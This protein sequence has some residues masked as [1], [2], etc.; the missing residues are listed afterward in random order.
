MEVQMTL[1]DRY[2]FYG[3]LI[4]YWSCM[5][6]HCQGVYI[7]LM[8]QKAEGAKAKGGL[9]DHL[10]HVSTDTFLQST[11]RIFIV[12]ELCKWFNILLYFSVPMQIKEHKTQT[13]IFMTPEEFA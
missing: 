1:A 13:Q 12:I 9:Q 4:A 7:N 2:L 3:Y 5:F 11:W 6:G 8:D 10:L